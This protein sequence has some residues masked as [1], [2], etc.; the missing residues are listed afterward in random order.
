MH[1]VILI[2]DHYRYQR[3][4][5]FGTNYIARH[6]YLLTIA[7]LHTISPYL[8][9]HTLL[10]MNTVTALLTALLE[11][12]DLSDYIIDVQVL[13]TCSLLG[14]LFLQQRCCGVTIYCICGDQKHHAVVT[15]YS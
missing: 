7:A 2:L 14:T 8:Q 4:Q 11:Y 1:G 10:H 6:N 12:L 15:V 13:A 5:T 9:L 3:G